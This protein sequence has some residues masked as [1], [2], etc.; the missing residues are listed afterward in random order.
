[1]HG[2]VSLAE[3]RADVPAT[4]RVQF[5]RHPYR[6]IPVR[7]KRRHGAALV[8]FPDRHDVPERPGQSRALI[9]T[10]LA[11]DPVAAEAAAAR[12]AIIGRASV[13]PVLEA[14]RAATPVQAVRLLS[15]LERIGDP[16]ALPALTTA[17]DDSNVEVAEA[18]IA[19]LSS[20]LTSPR[21]A[22]AT[23]AL[24]RLT[25]VTL[26]RARPATVRR[27]AFEA[28]AT[29]DLEAVALVRAQL[30]ADEDE[31]LRAA[32]RTTGT[33]DAAAPAVAAGDT[34]AREIIGAAA[35]GHLPAD[36]EVLRQ[37]LA[38]S[39]DVPLA[40]LHRVV[41][42]LRDEERRAPGT[43]AGWQVAR[44][45]VHQALAGRGSRLAVYDLRETI[46]QLGAATPVGVLSAL[47]AVGDAAALDA[48]A[49]A[50]MATGD[51]W[52]RGKLAATFAAI[53]RRE[54]LTRRHAAVR[55]LAQRAPAAVDALWPARQ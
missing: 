36:P 40:D 33:A 24:D 22:A 34:S 27:A 42:R 35:E 29:L 9:A 13:R 12:L 48:I 7:R 17:S 8:P 32:A 14:L 50:W 16:L 10:L 6:R 1:M 45:S 3:T 55:K 31:H 47:Q 20:L 49:D 51:R 37:A 39:D 52:F 28:L 54:S 26:D 53:V 25:A 2:G 44:A 30:L 15:V 18:A 38:A 41:Q 21:H 5:A 4:G 46:A 19:A 11:D 43:A 23:E